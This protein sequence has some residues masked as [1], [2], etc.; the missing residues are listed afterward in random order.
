M[1]VNYKHYQPNNQKNT[2]IVIL[3]IPIKARLLKI[4]SSQINTSKTLDNKKIL[5]KPVSIFP[6]II[7][8]IKSLNKQEKLD[9][10]NKILIHILHKFQYIKIN[11]VIQFKTKDTKSLD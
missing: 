3:L 10:M 5:F 1:K 8:N 6:F 7:Q 9:I 2:N 4:H 11:L